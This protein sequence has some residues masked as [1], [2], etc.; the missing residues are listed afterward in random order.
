MFVPIGIAYRNRPEPGG[1]SVIMPA[2]FHDAGTSRFVVV[3][4]EKLA[5]VWLVKKMLTS[6][7]VCPVVTKAFN[8]GGLVLAIIS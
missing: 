5:M 3:Y 4:S 8:K 6:S 7:G 2:K 1:F